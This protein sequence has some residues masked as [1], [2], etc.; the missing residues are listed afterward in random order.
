VKKLFV[1]AGA[2]VLSGCVTFGQ[3]D[4]GLASLVGRP[5]DVA[6]SVLG[7]PTGEQTLVG[8]HLVQW[9]RSTQGF[10]PMTTSSQAYGTISTSKGWGAY[11][12]MTAQTSY[13]PVNFNCSIT[14]QINEANTV[15]SYQYSGNLGGCKGYIR[16]LNAYRKGQGG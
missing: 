1:S 3:F 16:S 13:V 12:G 15:V 7:F 6:V 8:H 2:I 11:S 5:I 14:L 9:G 4:Q 10:M